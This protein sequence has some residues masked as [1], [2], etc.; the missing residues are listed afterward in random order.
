MFQ[1]GKEKETSGAALVDSNMI[2][3][4]PQKLGYVNSGEDVF[5]HYVKTP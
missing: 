1:V 2:V 4:V 3:R 5:P